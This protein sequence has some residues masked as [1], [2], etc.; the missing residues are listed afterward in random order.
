VMTKSNCDL[1]ESFCFYSP[2]R[3]DSTSRL[4]RAEGKNFRLQ[5][6]NDRAVADV[7]PRRS[8]LRFLRRLT[9]GKAFA[10]LCPFL[11]LVPVR[12]GVNG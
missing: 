5:K 7:N 4:R 12:I 11:C 8:C 6:H 10:G 9:F 1:T 2:C 3:L